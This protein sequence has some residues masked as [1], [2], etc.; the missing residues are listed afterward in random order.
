M[1]LGEIKFSRSR[2]TTRGRMDRRGGGGSG[3][4]REVRYIASE[5]KNVSSSGSS[6]VRSNSRSDVGNSSGSR[7]L[8][9]LQRYTSLARFTLSITSSADG[10][11]NC[12]SLLLS[13][14]TKQNSTHNQL[15]KMFAT[16]ERRLLGNR[17]TNAA[18]STYLSSTAL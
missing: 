2:N 1:E 16:H 17:C 3:R 6:I 4:C 7:R 15:L 8:T 5:A 18:P 13:P 14:K 11:F 9:L 12:H 10:R